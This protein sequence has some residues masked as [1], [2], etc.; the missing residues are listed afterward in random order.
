[1]LSKPE[2]VALL[3]WKGRPLAPA[4]AVVAGL[5]L[6]TFE[7][8]QVAALPHS[9]LQAV[10]VAA[11]ALTAAIGAHWLLASGLAG[12]QQRPARGARCVGPGTLRRAA[13]C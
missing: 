7:A 6:V 2:W 8:Y 4:A 1:M 11:G 3:A 9:S 12:R 10:Y 5:A 13:R